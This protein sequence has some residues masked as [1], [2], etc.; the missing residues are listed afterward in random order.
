[1]ETGIETLT[2][3]H[4]PH[5]E[6]SFLAGIRDVTELILIRHGEAEIAAAGSDD[7]WD[8][9]LSRHGEQQAERL[10][11]RLYREGGISRVYT[12]PL[13]RARMTATPVG[14]ELDLPVIDVYDLREVELRQGPRENDVRCSADEIQERFQRTGRWDSLPSAEPSAE[15]RA[16]VARALANIAEVN[17]QRKVAIICHGGVIN[18]Y[19][20]D[21]LGL[22]RDMFFLPDHASLNTVRILG[23]A[24]FIGRLNDAH[25]ALSSDSCEDGLEPFP[26][27]Q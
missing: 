18:A 25:H 24:R 6:R 26:A 22:E 15:L 2:F 21:M 12:S 20:A 19:L 16:R 9:P 17:A 14:F 8:P 5:F 1:M 27:W 10:A 13:R 11:H 3:E 23:E 7:W 4:A